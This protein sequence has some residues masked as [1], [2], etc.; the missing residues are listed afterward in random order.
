LRL[1]LRCPAKINL[2]LEVLGRRGDGFHELRTVFVAVGLWDELV[3]ERAAPG[4]L[5]LEVDPKGAVSGGEDNLVMRA[6]HGLLA[7]GS[8]GA[9]ARIL[10]RKRIPAAAGLGGGSADAAAALVG[11]SHLWGSKATAD[12]H[13]LAGTLGADVPYFLLGGVAWG[14]GRGDEV[15]PLADL[16]A[17]WA[18]LLP[19]VEP[20]STAE[21]YRLLAAAA[22]D[23]REPSAVYRWVIGGGTLPLGACRNELEP[24][25][26][27][28]WPWVGDRLRALRGTAPLLA[29]VS[30]SG[31]TVFAIYEDEGGAR[32]AAAEL[33]AL[34]PL[35]VP[36]LT[37]QGSQ[38]LPV[39][40]ET[41]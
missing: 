6:A 25:V 17:W 39:W 8:P 12:L 29:Q 38:L 15:H 5:E 1:S 35:A 24:T 21:V 14:V 40:E 33:V 41:R 31:G 22:L 4:C 19:G 20:V 27:E 34:S 11:L 32:R 36:V 10:L 28:H 23:E 9:G 16:P 7:T 2:H 26:V 37:R 13:G 18:V 30:G 3:F